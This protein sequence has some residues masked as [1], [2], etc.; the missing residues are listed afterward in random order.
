MFAVAGGPAEVRPTQQIKNFYR[1]VAL[2]PPGPPADPQLAGK[3]NLSDFGT[4]SVSCCHSLQLI[5]IYSLNLSTRFARI[6]LDT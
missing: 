6:M 5:L 2:A 3:K 4:L 1:P